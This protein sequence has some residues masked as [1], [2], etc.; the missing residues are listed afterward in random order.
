MLTDFPL[1]LP[2]SLSEGAQGPKITSGDGG[3]WGS[4]LGARTTESL[5]GGYEIV[6]RVNYSLQRE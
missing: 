2:P 6:L 1:I 4:R 3:Y 5:E